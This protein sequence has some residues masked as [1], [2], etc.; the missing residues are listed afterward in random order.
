MND[1]SEQI[2]ELLEALVRAESPTSDPAAQRAVVDLLE[3]ALAPAGYQFRRYPGKKSGGMVIARRRERSRRIKTT[4]R[5]FQLLLGH[6]DTVW[7]DGSLSIRRDHDRLYG[8]GAFDMK[9]GLAQA[10]FALK[11]LAEL[12]HE[13]P[14]EPVLFLNSDEESGSGESTRTIV[15]LAR[16]ARRVY[17]LEPAL[18]E[19]GKLKTARKGAGRFSI[20]LR[21]REAHSGLE[22][23]RGASAILEL[24]R[25]I[26]TLHALNDD[27]LGTTVNVG[28]VTGGTRAN[29]VAGE[30]RAEVDVRT[31]NESERVRVEALIR[32][33][34][35]SVPG[36]E[37]VVRGGI[38]RPP[39]E[40][41][42]RNRALW[43][44]AKQAA[45]A[46]DLPLEEGTAGGGSDGNTT[47]LY[48]ATLDGL[49]AVGDGAHATHEHALFS[50][51]SE[52]AALLALLLIAP[53][54]DSSS[55]DGSA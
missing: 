54:V 22:P 16:S 40:R 3:A 34:T 53:D 10:V 1:G 48:T 15:R 26:E 9:G 30:A 6:T 14:L 19:M 13:P 36:V 47:S 11:V 35:P 4:T 20:H 28:V 17:V 31:I 29:V 12:G 37:L 55:P 33:L 5:Q 52:R 2:A 24:A 39:L 27:S 42:P 50:R 21:G 32:A 7:A 44:L 49:G 18:G 46:L 51:C 41:T 38:D 23:E 45:A 8:P 25:V 43:A